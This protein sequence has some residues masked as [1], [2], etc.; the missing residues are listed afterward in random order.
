MQWRSVIG[1]RWSDT[2]QDYYP[3]A[4]RPRWGGDK[5]VHEGLHR[6]LDRARP[7]FEA[8]LDD[9]Y[10]YRAALY[11]VPIAP[12]GPGPCWDNRWFSCLDGAALTG[13][14]LRH[15]PRRY[16]EVGSGYST[17]FARHAI[18]WGGLE[19]TI[20]SIDPQPRVDIDSIC[21]EVIRRRL[22]DCELDLF[23][24][25]RPGD[26]LFFDGSHRVFTNSDTTVLFLDI[27]PRL[28][29]GVLV[30]FHDIFLPPDYPAVWN[31]RLYSEQY[32]LGAMLMCGSPPFEMRFAC[33]FVCAD[34]SLSTRVREIFEGRPAAPIPFFYR[35]ENEEANTPGLSF[36]VE[37]RPALFMNPPDRA[38]S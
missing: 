2:V 11:A 13:F 15:R 8:V 25:L 37:T 29:P 7:A 27:L 14:L 30:H 22:E 16:I 3:V 4:P 26:I 12:T 20:T 17:L 9:L 24:A 35:I 19:T 23:D 33:Y 34:P 36:W 18:R 31:G 28:R 5:P 32:L 1:E 38:A 6:C 21:D 10:R